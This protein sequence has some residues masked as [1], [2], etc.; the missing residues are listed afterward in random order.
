MFSFSRPR[1]R[2]PTPTQKK[3]HS[4]KLIEKND[5][6]RRRGEMTDRGLKWKHHRMT[7]IEHFL[8][9]IMQISFRDW[10][11]KSIA[12]I[13]GEIAPTDFFF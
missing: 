7:P 13:G 3:H 2:K 4:R 11:E 12:D 5:S 8:I 10:I 6:W 9:N 1:K